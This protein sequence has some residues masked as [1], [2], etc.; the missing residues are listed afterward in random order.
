MKFNINETKRI[1]IRSFLHDILIKEPVIRKRH[2]C[3]LKPSGYIFNVY[4]K[5]IKI[6]FNKNYIAG[7]VLFSSIK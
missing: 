2:F 3:L 5:I 7:N 4:F 1:T 6:T